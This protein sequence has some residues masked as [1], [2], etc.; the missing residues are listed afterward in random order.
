MKRSM[1][2]MCI[3]LILL[4]GCSHVMPNMG[5]PSWR[6][7]YRAFVGKKYKVVSDLRIMKQRKEWGS[8]FLATPTAT[9]ND[10]VEFIVAVPVGSILKINH[11]S[12]RGGFWLEPQTVFLGSCVTSNIFKWK[13]DFGSL[14][15]WDSTKTNVLGVNEMYLQPVP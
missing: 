1:V 6:P 15:R 8:Y 5:F 12:R 9:E 13:F 7:E 4:C 11:I 10:N 3:M 14:I 2:G